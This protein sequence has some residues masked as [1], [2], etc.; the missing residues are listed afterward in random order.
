VRFKRFERLLRA[1]L[2]LRVTVTQQGMVG[3]Y[4]RIRIRRLKLPVRVD[5]CVMPGSSRPAACPEA[6]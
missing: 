6:P 1:G 3:K 4:T 2:T 5:R